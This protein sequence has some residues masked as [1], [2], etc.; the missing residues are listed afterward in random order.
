MPFL[1]R[2]LDRVIIHR[3]RSSGGDLFVAFSTDVKYHSLSCRTNHHASM[4]HLDNTIVITDTIIGTFNIAIFNL[5]ETI[6]IW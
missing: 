3:P 4:F 2:P 1:V 6:F 5:A